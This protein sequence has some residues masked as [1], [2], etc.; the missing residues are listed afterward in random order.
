MQ[1]E[2]LLDI[3][4]VLSMVLKINT[5]SLS[6]DDGKYPVNDNQVLCLMAEAGLQK[7]DGLIEQVKDN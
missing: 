7:L 1:R 5:G 6:L 2:A 4:A 3:Q